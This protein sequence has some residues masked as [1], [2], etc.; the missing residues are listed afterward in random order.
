MIIRHNSFYIS[1][2][3]LVEVDRNKLMELPQL[4]ANMAYEY[5]MPSETVISITVEWR[6]YVEY[7][8]PSLG[9]Q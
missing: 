7:F 1:P 8:F 9:R 3:A 2:T 6:Y 4:Y 5:G